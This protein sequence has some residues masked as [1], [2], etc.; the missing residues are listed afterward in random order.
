MI[1]HGPGVT[2]AV[3]LASSIGCGIRL[4]EDVLRPDCTRMGF[5]MQPLREALEGGRAFAAS[6]RL[7]CTGRTGLCNPC[8][9]V[10]W[11][12]ADSALQTRAQSDTPMGSKCQ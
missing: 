10:C 7:E 12:P 3:R 9:L 4:S 2:L 11:R 5:C 1:C 6:A 8:R